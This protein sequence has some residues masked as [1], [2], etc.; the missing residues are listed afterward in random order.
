MKE[1]HIHLV[2]DSTGETVSVVARASLVQFE[3]TETT[4]H[5]WTMIRKKSQVKSVLDGVRLHPGFVLY[6]LVDSKI[7]DELESGC[8]EL[9]IPCVSVLKPIVAALGMHLG[10][11]TRARPGGQHVMDAEYYHRIDA[12]HFVLSH[13]DGQSTWDLDEADVV[14]LGVS[15]TSKTPTCIYLANRGVKAANVPIVPGFDLPVEVLEAVR[16]LMIGLTA[17]ARQLVQIRRNRLRLLKEAEETD[18]VDLDTVTGEVNAARR[19][20]TKHRWPVID[21]TR[22]SIEEIAA[23]IINYS[24]RRKEEHP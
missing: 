18:Y 20:F 13:D 2:S 8:R 7:R 6:T 11:E 19:L 17:D 4:E 9:G 1:F 5:T 24:N 12:M 21:V 15:R 14:V 22:R 10:A 16:P 23:T 3:K